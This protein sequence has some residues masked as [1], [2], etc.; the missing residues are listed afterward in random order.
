MRKQ[1]DL[2]KHSSLQTYTRYM[3]MTW[4]Y[5]VTASTDGR[6]KGVGVEGGAAPPPLLANNKEKVDER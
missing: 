1:H 2:L 4:C 3:V 6:K 5:F